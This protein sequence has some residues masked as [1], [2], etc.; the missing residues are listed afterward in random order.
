MKRFLLPLLAALAL[1]TAINAEISDKVHNRCKDASDYMGCVKANSD[2]KLSIK[3]VEKTEPKK[4]RPAWMVQKLKGCFKYT[5]ETKKNYCIK[6]YSPYGNPIPENLDFNSVEETRYPD[7]IV[8]KGET[9]NASRICP[10][11]ER[12]YWQKTS[13]FMRKTKVSE[14][15]CM[16][17]SENEEYWRNMELGKAGAPRG[18]SY[19]SDGYFIKQQMQ[20]QRSTDNYKR[21]LDNYQRDMGY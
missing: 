5:D 10:A 1:P 20:M 12:M 7:F 21:T 3:S 15:G 16:T 8:F 9:I 11:G 6:T 4:Q 14:L 2:N 13:G 19:N 18:G 17:A